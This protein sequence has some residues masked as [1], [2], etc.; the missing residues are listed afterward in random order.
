MSTA[1]LNTSQSEGNLSNS[2]LSDARREKLM[3][4]KKREDLKGALENKFKSRFGHGSTEKQDDEVSLASTTIR[5]EVDNF[6]QSAAVTEAN[7]GRLE[8]RLQQRAVPRPTDAASMISAYS[9]T[10][11]VASLTGMNVLRGNASTTGS[12]A[13]GDQY[14]WEKLDQYAAYLHE[15][16]S[17]RQ[18][19]GVHALQKKLRM[20]LD[21]QVEEKKKRMIDA[22][23]EDKHYF[24]NTMADLEKWKEIEKERAAEKHAQIM[25]EKSDRDA[26]LAFEKQLKNEELDKKK[27][28]E[29]SL[30]EKIVTEMEQEQRR[31]EIKKEKT[32]KAMKKVFEENQKDQD[33][34][35]EE[36][37]K[38]QEKEAAAIKAYME[39]MDKMEE[40]R[41][42]ET[43]A[44]I[45]RQNEL[46]ASLM[47]NMDG[48]KKENGDNDGMRALA[49]QEE[50]D[51]HYFEAEQM[52]QMRL[53]QLKLENQA[54]LK[55]QMDEKM[56]R[57]ADEQ[58]LK[59]IQAHI[60]EADSQEYEELEKA[61][62]DRKRATLKEN[63]KEV[64][65]QM[66]S[67]KGR[68]VPM[69]SEQEIKFN[70]PL[71]NLVNR[72]LA[73]AEPMPAEGDDY[74]DM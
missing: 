38:N 46:M 16:D 11:S 5:K 25:R 39:A 55:K 49:Q 37:Q 24:K 57:G 65:K 7:L 45:D 35:K 73:S 40:Q 64:L 14:S 18:R 47:D 41:A 3:N 1:R 60:L 22:G 67:K 72:T 66:E 69:M 71:L 44:R 59:A 20:D 15:Q 62:V 12:Q 17:L 6:A 8:R 51:K 30:V 43:K 28:E 9:G 58:E 56:G 63:Q 21:K 54:Y 68:S 42:A 10:R 36:A 4:L 29:A 70:K 32:K 2:R 52:K 33:R 26:Q 53:K 74:D 34:K 23:Q 61:K 31:F 27:K 48:L 19:L 50:M 13:Q